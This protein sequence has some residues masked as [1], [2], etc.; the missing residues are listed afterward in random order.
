VYLFLVVSPG[1]PDPA[2][3]RI[4]RYLHSIIYRYCES[5]ESVVIT[6]SSLHIVPPALKPQIHVR[7]PPAPRSLEKKWR[8]KRRGRLPLLQI[9][10]RVGDEIDIPHTGT[11]TVLFA[12]KS[13]ERESAAAHLSMEMIATIVL[14]LPLV[15]LEQL[16]L[17]PHPPS[18]SKTDETQN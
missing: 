14:P 1:N 12:A 3:T 6:S 5:N 11:P 10:R 9:H 15:D 16:G 18:F 2:V 7:P 8:R 4:G 17:T 13:R